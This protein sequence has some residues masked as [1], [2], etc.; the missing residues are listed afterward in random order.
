[1][2]EFFA[3]WVGIV[4]SVF[5]SLIGVQSQKQYEKDANTPSIVPFI[6]V[7]IVM[8][9]LFVITLWVLVNFLVAR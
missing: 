2:S 7:G 3:Y 1:M 6:A 4:K 5:A 9:A 8:V